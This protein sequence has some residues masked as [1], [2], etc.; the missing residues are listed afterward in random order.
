MQQLD[1]LFLQQY[2]KLDHLMKDM[3]SSQRGVSDYLEAM[4]E[5]ASD[6]RRLCVLHWD[7][8]YHMLKHLRWLRNQ[9]AHECDEATFCD[10][11]DLQ[12]LQAFYQRAIRQD[13]PFAR[14][15]L[16]RQQQAQEQSWKEAQAQAQ[17]Q[18]PTQNT[19]RKLRS[20]SRS[21]CM[22]TL[23]LL[24]LGCLILLFRWLYH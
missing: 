18:M 9:I 16:A 23:F 21:L 13:D 24:L 10:E 14:L 20:L 3:L 8:D 15:A 1:M 12:L 17:Q 7:D 11:M 2:I 6:A 5:E 22:M 4:E 19:T